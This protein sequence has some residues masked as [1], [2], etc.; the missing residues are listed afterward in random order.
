MRRTFAA[1]AMLAV[2]LILPTATATSF[3]GF[4]SGEASFPYLQIQD[5]SGAATLTVDATAARPGG[6]GAIIDVTNVFTEGW[7]AK[8]MLADGVGANQTVA[9]TVIKPKNR[10][11]KPYKSIP[12]ALRCAG[13]A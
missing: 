13:P 7:L 11:I 1:P 10:P 12:L 9:T 3:A 5:T 6:A 4:E 8:V 2:L